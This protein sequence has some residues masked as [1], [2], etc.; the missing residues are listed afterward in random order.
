[1]PDAAHTCLQDSNVLFCCARHSKI[2]HEAVQLVYIDLWKFPLS[3]WSQS[4][5]LY[6]CSVSLAGMICIWGTG[7]G[8]FLPW[9]GRRLHFPHVLPSFHHLGKFLP[10][11]ATGLNSVLCGRHPDKKFITLIRKV[12]KTEK[13][14]CLLKVKDWIP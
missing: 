14:K 11:V 5:L 7:D 1:M 3:Q 2:L 9:E 13:Q 6:H 12:S 8:D 10:F 4:Y